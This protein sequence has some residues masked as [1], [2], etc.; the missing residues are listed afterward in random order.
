[1]EKKWFVSLYQ[2]EFEL[3]LNT[4]RYFVFFDRVLTSSEEKIG[5]LNFIKRYNDLSVEQADLIR[6][7]VGSYNGPQKGLTQIIENIIS[8]EK[9]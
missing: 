7:K 1:M 4:D 5:N 8:N 3:A 6:S 2:S 9:S